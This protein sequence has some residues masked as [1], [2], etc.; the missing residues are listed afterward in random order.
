MFFAVF[1]TS[2]TIA[3]GEHTTQRTKIFCDK[4]H[5]RT[6]RSLRKV[7]TCLLR[8][9]NKPVYLHK[10]LKQLDKLPSWLQA[11]TEQWLPKLGNSIF[12]TTFMIL[13]IAISPHP[14]LPGF[15]PRCF[16]AQ[17]GGGDG[18]IFSNEA[19][20]GRKWLIAE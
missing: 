1:N 16:L 12:Y 8:D 11:R 7:K 14:P 20:G 9:S 15:T 3:N 13:L 18:K 5:T 4:H 6:A 10:K 17:K 19:K 2:I